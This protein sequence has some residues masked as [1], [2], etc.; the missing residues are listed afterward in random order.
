MTDHATHG[1]PHGSLAE[2]AAKL[3]EAAQ[4]WLG[5]RG[6]APAADVWA[7]ATAED[8]APPCRGCPVCRARAL[9]G[10]VS[11]EVFE[12]LADA[13]ASLGAAL[14]SL[15]GGRDDGPADGP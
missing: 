4:L 13:A 12:H 11:P 14:R 2:E 3:A 9:L 6:A 10:E 5:Q 7:E 15:R 8:Q 1:P